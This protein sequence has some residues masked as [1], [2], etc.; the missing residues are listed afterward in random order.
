MYPYY[1]RKKLTKPIACTSI[2]KDFHFVPTQQTATNI[3]TTVVTMG[4]SYNVVLKL[5][6]F[7]VNIMY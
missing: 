2:L 4:I 6:G 3:S 5:I 7:N 1:L